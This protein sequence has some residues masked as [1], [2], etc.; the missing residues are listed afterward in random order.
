MRSCVQGVADAQHRHYR[1]A[2]RNS[3]PDLLA[4]SGGGLIVA[5]MAVDERDP[6]AHGDRRLSICF[7]GRQLSWIG[8]RRGTLLAQV[9]V[10]F[11]HLL[12]PTWTAP[13]GPGASRC[14]GRGVTSCLRYFAA[15]AL[16]R[17]YVAGSSEEALSCGWP[18]GAIRLIGDVIA[19][20]R[21][22]RAVRILNPRGS[23]RASNPQPR[24]EP[25]SGSRQ[26]TDR[27]RRRLAPDPNRS[28]SSPPAISRGPAGA[29][30]LQPPRRSR[31]R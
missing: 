30:K 8:F 17:A 23:S 10:E 14:R 27:P 3:D 26:G 6:D 31:P 20:Q 4:R 21:S 22:A 19:L 25:W 1:V 7:A 16:R 15:P 28:R 9:H 12:A 18:L 2:T 13:G 24:P 5:H 29:V 11:A